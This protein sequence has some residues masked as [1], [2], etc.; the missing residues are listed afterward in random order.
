MEIKQL[1]YFTQVAESG[2]FLRAAAALGVAQPTLSRQ[3]SRLER[4]LGTVLLVRHVRGVELTEAGARLRDHAHDILRAVDTA[5]RDLDEV[6]SVPRGQIAL[7]VTPTLVH[8]LIPPLTRAFRAQ[9]PAVSIKV[10]EGLSGHVYEWLE[11][12]EIQLGLLYHAGEESD[13]VTE[14]LIEE[15][16]YLVAPAG[17][18]V[19]QWPECRMTDLVGLPMI[20]PGMP[21]G[22]RRVVEAAAEREGVALEIAMELDSLVL[23]RDSILDGQGYALLPI[24]PVA[25]DIEEGRL[26]A[27]PV[28][29]GLSRTLYL[30]SKTG[31]PL[32]LA[33]RELAKAIRAQAKQLVCS[34]RWP[35]GTV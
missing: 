8:L 23:T 25:Q 2:S 7:G 21:H 30:A 14:P 1:R 22:L 32:S 11:T 17:S 10:A 15:A 3:I 34:G 12:G 27:V 13:L 31:I 9:H 18:A 4:N 28:R 26:T 5:L 29:P 6:K 33:T 20:V 24:A 35:G 19:G 16:L